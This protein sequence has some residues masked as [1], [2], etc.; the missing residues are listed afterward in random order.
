MIWLILAPNIEELNLQ[1]M[2]ID[3]KV[4]L[5]TEL[6]ELLKTDNFVTP[7][8]FNRLPQVKLFHKWHKDDFPT[9]QKLF[10]L[11]SEIFPKAIDSIQK[12]CFPVVSK[13]NVIK[14][15]VPYMP[16]SLGC[17]IR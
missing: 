7:P 11:F 17:P 14:K 15:N 3:A 5:A 1:N 8:I 10:L 4:A 16:L 6:S 2:T 12:N 13:S 9:K